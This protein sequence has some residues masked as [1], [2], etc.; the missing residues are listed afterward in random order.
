MRQSS[1]QKCAS[2]GIATLA[3]K[4]IN[5]GTCIGSIPRKCL[6][7]HF[8]SSSVNAISRTPV[9]LGI[10]SREN[11]MPR[12]TAHTTSEASAS[13][14]GQI[15]RFGMAQRNKSVRTTRW[16]FAHRAQTATSNMSKML[17]RCRTYRLNLSPTSLRKKTGSIDA[18]CIKVATRTKLGSAIT[19][20]RVATSRPIAR[21]RGSRNRI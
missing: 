3:R 8:S 10:L 5:V 9:S 20:A 6:S 11:L 16:V 15:A 12:S 17:W 18:N 14:A 2:I 7:A 19:V 21:S 4:V 13:L 1:S